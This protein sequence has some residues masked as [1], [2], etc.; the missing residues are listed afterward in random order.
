MREWKLYMIRTRQG[1]LYT[2]IARDVERRFEEHA[3]GAP[4][5]AKYFRGKGPLELVFQHAVGT[6][7]QALQAEAAIKKLSK[8]E[9]EKLVRGDLALTSVLEHSASQWGE[10]H[11][12]RKG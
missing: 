10:C 7:S 1:S 6:R 3:R 4:S 11:G 8:A 12:G 5:G 9:K 2:G